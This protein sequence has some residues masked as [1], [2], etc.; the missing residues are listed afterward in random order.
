M[1][2]YVLISAE[3]AGKDAFLDGSIS[4]YTVAERAARKT[5]PTVIE[6]EFFVAGWNQAFWDEQERVLRSTPR[7]G[8]NQP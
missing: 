6:R 8:S 4:R 7:S 3:Q 1:T 5:Y 2:N